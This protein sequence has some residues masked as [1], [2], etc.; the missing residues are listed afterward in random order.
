MKISFTEI[1]SRWEG[2]ENDQLHWS[3]MSLVQID[4]LLLL[5]RWDREELWALLEMVQWEMLKSIEEIQLQ[6]MSTEAKINKFSIEREQWGGE[7]STLHFLVREDHSCCIEFLRKQFVRWFKQSIVNDFQAI[8]RTN[9]ST[10][11]S[12]PTTTMTNRRKSKKRIIVKR[13]Q[14]NLTERR[15]ISPEWTASRDV[16]QFAIDSVLRFSREF[17][18]SFEESEELVPTETEMWRASWSS[19]F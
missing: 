12:Q 1:A 4:L 9:Q 6:L 10:I 17:V 19:F 13:I 8:K 2:I 15:W 3:K 18:D 7:M 14:C 11:F 5:L 16:L